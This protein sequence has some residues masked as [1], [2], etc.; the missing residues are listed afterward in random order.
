MFYSCLFLCQSARSGKGILEHFTVHSIIFNLISIF[1]AQDPGSFP[2]LYPAVSV[3]A[4]SAAEQCKSSAAL[5]NGSKSEQAGD[6]PSASMSMPLWWQ[7]PWANR[8][9]H[10]LAGLHHDEAGAAGTFT[11]STVMV[12]PSGRPSLSVIR[13]RILGFA[14]Q[15]GSSLIAQRLQRGDGFC[16]ASLSMDARTAID[17]ADDLFD[18]WP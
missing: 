12:K 11:V 6:L 10:D 4:Q 15:M 14:M 9:G 13:Q 18:S 1:H 5:P 8:H 17:P 3:N 16:R 2:L 7:A